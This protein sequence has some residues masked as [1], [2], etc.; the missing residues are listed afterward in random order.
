MSRWSTRDSRPT[1]PCRWRP[2][3]CQAAALS[4]AAIRAKL[5]HDIDTR[6]SIASRGAADVG[7]QTS[8]E[9]RMIDLLVK[10]AVNA[11]ALIAAANV[12]P[13]FRFVFHTDRP[14]DWLKIAVIALVFALVNSYIKP[15][16]KTLA[17]PIG[18]MTMGLVAF[19]INAAMLL[20]TAWGV[21]QFVNGGGFSFTVGGYPVH[22]GYAAI[23]CAVVAS[24][25]ISI[26][27][28]ILSL[29]LVPRKVVGF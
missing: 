22:W 17:L 3:L 15:I 11:V 28:T 1:V 19:V 16:V 27:S 18:F 13:D 7:A 14:E 25:V 20:G 23:G 21:N 10:V 26:V 9:T 29:V 2:R 5:R 4:R 24:I 6:A 12:V 8:E